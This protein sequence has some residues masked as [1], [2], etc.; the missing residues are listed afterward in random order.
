MMKNFY[1]DN[2]SQWILDRW[3]L[4]CNF[5]PIAHGGEDLNRLKAGVDAPSQ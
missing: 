5:M 3:L 4:I 2:S 1:A